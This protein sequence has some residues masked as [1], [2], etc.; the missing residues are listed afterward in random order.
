MAYINGNK[1][2][3]SSN[4]NIS[5]GSTEDLDVE[6]TEQETLLN[7]LE[8]DVNSLE[9]KPKT[10]G[11]YFVKVIDYDGTILKEAK[12]DA[13][14]TFELPT[15]PS[16][17][18]LVFQE[19]SCS[20]E[21]V[22]NTITITD[23]NV[24]VGA[25]YTTASGLNEFD[26]ELTKVT[27]LAVTLN[28]DGTKD[29][30][31]GTSDDLTTHTYTD[32]GKYTIKCNGTTMTTS[33]TS[34][35]FGQKSSYPNY[36]CVNVR[37]A[38][39]TSIGAYSFSNCYSLVSMTIPSGETSISTYAFNCCH[40]LTSVVIPNGVTSIGD[41]MFAYCYSLT[42]VVIP[43]GVTNVGV[44]TFYTCYSLI[45]ITIPNGVTKIDTSMFYYCNTLTNI[46]IPNSVTYIGGS[47]FFNCYSLVNVIIPNNVTIIESRAFYNCHSLT[48]I[49][50][51]SG[52]T[53]IGANAFFGC[54]SL[55]N[56]TIPNGVK[57]LEGSLFYGCYKL[58]NITIPN[59][60]TNIGSSTF[61]QCY[62][63][64][65][66]TIPNGVT[67]VGGSAFYACYSITSYDFS[68]HT[69][70]PTLAG[71]NAFTN[72]NSIAKIIVP[73]NLYDEWIV[74]TNWATYADYIYKASEV[75]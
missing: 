30:G 40:S 22:D 41:S 55:T 48:N 68:T 38:N 3:F 4:V 18:G 1:I 56:I 9:D 46:I 71:T 21:I 20:Q 67:N 19:W 33:S 65:S 44:S 37:F 62:S 11:E 23:N 6:L 24:M 29:W 74:A 12:L 52:V 61:Q 16:H 64:A 2:A 57:R 28:M 34:G 70:V 50:I 63:L 7:E 39:I 60:V 32:Y 75:Q 69:A 66:I 58:T 13:G 25:V 72:I 73:D 51:P 14:D 53:S 42:S 36:Y 45:N 10:D 49:T 47:A 35:L 27:G 59:N 5:I 43:N 54:Y 8:T 26:I 31:D 17:D 15:P